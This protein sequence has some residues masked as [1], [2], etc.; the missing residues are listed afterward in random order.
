M[1]Y[2]LSVLYRWG[3]WGTELF[4]D[5][6]HSQKAEETDW[7]QIYQWG[8]V[9]F[10][11]IGNPNNPGSSKKEAHR[12]LKLESPAVGQATGLFWARAF[13]IVITLALFS[14]ILLSH[15]QAGIAVPGPHS[16]THASQ[17]QALVQEVSGNLWG[18]LWLDQPMSS[19]LF[20]TS[21]WPESCWD[22]L[23]LDHMSCLPPHLGER[24]SEGF[25]ILDHF[26]LKLLFV[27]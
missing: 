21:H 19:A 15:G 10:H 22:R 12:L 6:P 24:T 20:S 4:S 18:S 2:V 14:K 27:I 1:K 25:L 26:Y 9:W 23:N 8:C 3:N 11:V 7:K 16:H 13:W 17:R 5:L